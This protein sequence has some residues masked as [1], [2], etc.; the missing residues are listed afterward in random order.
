MKP[1]D[2]TS[3]ILIVDDEE[4]LLKA[5]SDKFSTEGFTVI[6]A[7]DGQ[8]GLQSALREHPDVILLDVIM[9]KMDGVTML[10]KLRE[11]E[12]GKNVP[13]IILTNLSSIDKTY[14]PSD[15]KVYD[16]LVKTDWTLDELVEKV[17]EKLAATQ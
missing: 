16:Y 4:M 5:L 1:S 9:P 11:D 8:D 3:K 17:K 15:D 12:W 7:K 10:K 14:I 13:V 2:N 6:S